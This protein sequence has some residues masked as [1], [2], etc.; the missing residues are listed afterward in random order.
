MIDKSHKLKGVC[1]DIRGPVLDAAKRL[2]DNG[3]KILRLNIGN[4]AAFYIKGY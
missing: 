1:Y 4:P 3:N 2:E